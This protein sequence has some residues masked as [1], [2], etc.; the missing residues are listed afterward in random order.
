MV[1]NIGAFAEAKIDAVVSKTSQLWFKPR[2][3]R[4]RSSK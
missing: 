1:Q 4:A 3:A 2:I